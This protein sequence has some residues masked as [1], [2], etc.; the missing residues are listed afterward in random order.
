MFG[1]GRLYVTRFDYPV[2]RVVPDGER[3]LV[4]CPH[5][6]DDV[7]GVG[8]TLRKHIERGVQV[9]ILVLTDGGAGVPNQSRKEITKL[10]RQE[11]LNAASA[12]GIE[13]LHF[14]NIPDGALRASKSLASK[15]L[16]LLDK[17]QPDLV[18]LPSFLDTHPDHRAVTSL[19]ALAC[20]NSNIEFN[21]AAYELNVPILPNVVI[22]I[23]DQIEF[24]M[25]ALAAHQSQ[26]EQVN[27]EDLVLFFARWRA[28]ALTKDATYA[29][30]FYI[31]SLKGY[32][33]LWRRATEKF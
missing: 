31:D 26:L 1:I 24:K 8:G 15:L 30:T 4:L 27:Y 29:E 6:D 18:Y 25:Q 28:A 11:Q 20:K 14:W 7:I 19:L 3:I 17:I 5:P 13:R 9:T 2:I 10:R 22:N 32:L 21:C 12:L 16:F 33:D 23:S